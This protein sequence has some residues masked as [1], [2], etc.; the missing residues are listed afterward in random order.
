MIQL[1]ETGL[2]VVAGLIVMAVSAFF[3]WRHGYI[4][5]RASAPSV[6]QQNAVDGTPAARYRIH[7]PDGAVGDFGTRVQSAEEVN[8][9]NGNE[10]TIMWSNDGGRTWTQYPSQT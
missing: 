10:G 8:A 7:W 6:R 1:E 2:F 9:K 4:G 3:A 5:S